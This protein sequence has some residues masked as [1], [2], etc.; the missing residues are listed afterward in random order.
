MLRGRADLGCKEGLGHIVRGILEVRQLQ[1][2]TA[3]GP[4]CWLGLNTCLHQNSPYTAL[5]E[6]YTKALGCRLIFG[7]QGLAG[8]SPLQ[9]S[10]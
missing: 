3:G 1:Q 5:C 6:C 4:P 8:C 9:G 10:G 2:L 7:V